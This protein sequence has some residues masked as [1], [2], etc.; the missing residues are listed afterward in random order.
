MI[1]F[2]DRTDADD[3]GDRLDRLLDLPPSAKLAFLVLER[4][5]PLTQTALAERTLLPRRTTRAAVNA[6]ERADVVEETPYRLDA[7]KKAYRARPVDR[8]RREG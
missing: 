7:R 2:V 1:A 3:P 6:L 4:E 5:G 8:E